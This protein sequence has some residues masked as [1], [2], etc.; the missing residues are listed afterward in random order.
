MILDGQNL[1]SNAQAVTADA[2]STNI[3]DLGAEIELGIG[4]PMGVVFVV[5]VAA[6]SGSAGTY[7]FN[8]EVDALE[9][10][11]SVIAVASVTVLEA[12]LVAGYR[13]VLMIPPDKSMERFLR[14]GYDTGGTDPTVTITAFLQPLSMIQN[15]VYH[16]DAITITG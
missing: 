4:E 7:T 6:S 13:F 14:I 11:A 8:L 2:A 12:T 9:A 5:D 1:L 3:I 10:M 15:D 16:P